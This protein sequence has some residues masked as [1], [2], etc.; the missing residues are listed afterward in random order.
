MGAA[1]SVKGGDLFAMDPVPNTRGT[2]EKKGWVKYLD[3]YDEPNRWGTEAFAQ[4]GRE[5]AST[6]REPG[7]P[8]S[9]SGTIHRWY[10]MTYDACGG[11]CTSAL[12]SWDGD[13][14]QQAG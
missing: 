2:W 5:L 4:A 3:G 14:R 8:W 10:R 9:E 1:L 13:S 6:L 11:K 7:P 12:T